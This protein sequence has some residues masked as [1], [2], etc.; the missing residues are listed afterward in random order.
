M[1]KLNTKLRGCSRESSVSS[2]LASGSL[3]GS[4]SHSSHS[5]F[6]YKDQLYSSASEA[7]QAYIDDFDLSREHPGANAVKVNTDGE[8]GNGLQFSSYV[9]TPDN[10]DK[11]ELLI[12][13]AKKNLKQSAKDLP[14][15]VEKDD[16]PCS[17]DKLEAERTWENVPVAL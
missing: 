7:L 2:L 3:S 11:I 4:S 17:L 16:S 5:S 9:H 8:I 6:V 14:K 10:G 12:L 15:P 13:K 1:A